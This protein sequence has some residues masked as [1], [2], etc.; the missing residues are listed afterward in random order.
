MLVEFSKQQIKLR[1]ELREYFLALMTNDLKVELSTESTKSGGGPLFKETLKQIGQDGWI[2]LSWPK[3]YSLNSSLNLICCFE[4]STSIY[5][6]S[7][8][9]PLSI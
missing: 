9:I 3:K 7:R 2:G 6:D 1:E 5:L 4:N 8:I